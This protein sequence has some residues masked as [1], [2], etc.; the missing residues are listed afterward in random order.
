M[1]LFR[2]APVLLAAGCANPAIDPGEDLPPLSTE[3][4]SDPVEQ[5]QEPS[6]PVAPYDSYTT[7]TSLQSVERVGPRTPHDGSESVPL[8][9]GTMAITADFVIIADPDQDHVVGWN[10]RADVVAWTLELA[11]GAEPFR[12]TAS[13][14]ERTI[15][16]TLRGTGDVLSLNP[17]NGDLAHQELACPEPRGVAATSDHV[18]VACASG[19]LVTFRPDLTHVSSDLVSPDLRD[20]VIN[21]GTLWVSRFRQATVGNVN[22]RDGTV[23]WH[24]PGTVPQSTTSYGEVHGAWRMRGRPGGG[25]L[26]VHQ[27]H[28]LS[29][30]GETPEGKPLPPAAPYYG[31]SEVCDPRLV[32]TTHVTQV[33]GDGTLWTSGPLGGSVLGVDL[34]V[35]PAGNLIVAAVGGRRAQ[36][37]TPWLHIDTLV[38][39]ACHTPTYKPLLNVEGDG[40]LT[41]LALDGAG[42]LEVYGY[43]TQPARLLHDWG[44]AETLP[45][46]P[47]S[48]SRGPGFDNF[49]KDVGAQITCASCHLEGEEDGH[50]WR[51]TEIGDRRTQTLA[52]GVSQRAP[53][54]W[55]AEF[56]SFGTLM[57]EVFEFRMNGPALTA[58][59]ASS[60]LE[61]IDQIRTS[62]STPERGDLVVR[63]EGVFN[64]ETVAC[65]SC[66]SG[67]DFSDHRMHVVREGDPPRKT[68]TLLG[69]G[70]RGPYMS[71]GCAPT[72]LDRFTDAA[73]GGGDLH[74][75]TSGL[76]ADDVEAL[77]AYL[78]T[79]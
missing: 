71:D 61:Y 15:Y 33:D 3:S 79:L 52:G 17:L 31:S 60:L 25:V 2:W 43:Q 74:G 49:H 29:V 34:A 21:D 10:R 32:V 35:E 66:H 4:G 14:D 44:A 45:E 40:V 8:Y 28:T 19:E 22:L 76:D 68:P 42:N 1:T 39:E 56:E 62:E 50:V 36:V 5:I 78:H 7:V 23:I 18:Y 70:A 26:W 73:C 12:A 63:G 55:A 41:S 72:L 27:A 67:P 30:V 64:H 65:A 6:A 53:F 9:G 48:T 51:F 77:V 75:T 59:E 46:R 57:E 11:P 13:P 58:D 24:H 69:I 38:P 16:V 20:V 47:G 54:H 37:R